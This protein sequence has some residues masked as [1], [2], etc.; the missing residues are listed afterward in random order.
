MKKLLAVLIT[1]ILAASVFASDSMSLR[2][3][4]IVEDGRISI[5]EA[6]D[7]STGGLYILSVDGVKDISSGKEGDNRYLMSDYDIAKHDIDIDFTVVQTEKVQTLGKINLT[8][9]VGSLVL[10]ADNTME[11]EAST[12]GSWELANGLINYEDAVTVTAAAVDNIVSIEV[13]YI[14][15]TKEVPPQAIGKF[16]AKWARDPNLLKNP[17][18]YKANVTLSYTVE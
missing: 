18:L 15:D 4:S 11:V 1:L 8:A 10:D 2:L 6:N 16:T 3:K 13:K 12:A 7:V 14:D 5:S 17:G 9:T